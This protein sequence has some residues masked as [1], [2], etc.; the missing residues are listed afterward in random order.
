[1]VKRYKESSNFSL[2]QLI[3]S[4]LEIRNQMSTNTCWAFTGI[5]SLETNLALKDYINKTNSGNEKIYDFSE[6]HM[7]Y[8]MSQSFKNNQLNKYGYSYK[9][10][11]GG[12]TVMA[13]AYL[14]NGQGAIN[15][16]DMPFVDNEDDINLSDIQNK[17]V[18]TTVNNII[19]FDSIE[20]KE[21]ALTTE[22]NK[23]TELKEQMKEHIS[24]YGSV[25][26]AVYVSEE[27]D[28]QEGEKYENNK[29]G[30]TI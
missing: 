27:A 15:E 10:N 7:A 28:S 18:Q 22:A 14:T 29:T 26:A 30:N 1:M 8:T 4:N 6:R 13:T 11:A 23:L 24:T 9:V 21:N 3:P 19:Y 25:S 5:S 12:S 20:L 16:T 2:K 17:T